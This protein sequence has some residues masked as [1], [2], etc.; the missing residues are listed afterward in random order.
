[1]RLFLIA[2]VTAALLALAGGLLL[3][4]VEE[5]VSTAFSSESVRL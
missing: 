4:Q 2:V 1:M 3:S 5:P